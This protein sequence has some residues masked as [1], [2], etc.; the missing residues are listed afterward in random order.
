M[1]KWTIVIIVVSTIAQI[2]FLIYTYIAYDSFFEEQKERSN[3]Y[4]TLLVMSCLVGDILPV[5]AFIIVQQSDF[6]GVY[7]SGS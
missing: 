6:L 4:Y 5:G 1:L 7:G 2:T 3:A